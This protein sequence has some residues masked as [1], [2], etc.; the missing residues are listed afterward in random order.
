M[1]QTV[2]YITHMSINIIRIQKTLFRHLNV[3]I[4]FD[5]FVKQL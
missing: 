5:E 2:K 3:L 4:D 1:A